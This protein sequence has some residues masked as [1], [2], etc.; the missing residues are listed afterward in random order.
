M[1]FS[2]LFNTCLNGVAHYF[3]RRTAIASLYELDDRALRDIGLERSQIEAAVHGFI[4]LSR[5]NTNG[6]AASA[7]ATGLRAHGQPR[8]SIVEA[9]LWN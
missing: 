7:V 3:V 5:T 1:A 9:S 6:M 4:T 8:S 2:R